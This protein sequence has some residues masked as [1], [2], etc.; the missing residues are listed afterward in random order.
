MSSRQ[1]VEITAPTPIRLS[2]HS[3]P[4]MPAR[5]LSSLSHQQAV[6]SPFGT[7]EEELSSP[8]EPEHIPITKLWPHYPDITPSPSPVPED[9]P[10]DAIAQFRE[11]HQRATGFEDDVTFWPD[12]PP[13]SPVHHL[14]TAAP[15][16]EPL[17]FFM[18]YYPIMGAFDPNQS[19]SKQLNPTAKAFE[20]QASHGSVQSTA[21]ESHHQALQ[22]GHPI[23]E[24]PPAE[25]PATEPQTEA[26][27]A[28]LLQ[29]QA[30]RQGPIRLRDLL[31]HPS[32][33]K[34]EIKLAE[35]QSLANVNRRRAMKGN[36]TA[37]S[38]WSPNGGSA[39]KSS[40]G[41][42]KPARSNGPSPISK[43]SGPFAPGYS[44]ASGSR[45]GPSNFPRYQ[46]SWRSPP[47]AK[48]SSTA[49]GTHRNSPN[50]TVSASPTTSQSGSNSPATSGTAGTSLPTSPTP[51]L[52]PTYEGKGTGGPSETV[53][54]PATPGTSRE[55]RTPAATTGEQRAYA[56]AA[57]PPRSPPAPTTGMAGMAGV[58][59]GPSMQRRGRADA[60]SWRGQPPTR[61]AEDSDRSPK[62]S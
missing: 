32:R 28:P 22:P 43:S 44:T 57:S 17:F 11:D 5:P 18:P 54:R 14:D 1:L 46:G 9:G 52:S 35:A 60:N 62:S 3:T 7:G 30:P 4:F 53:V 41:P 56:Q 31:Y 26:A 55:P 37:Q 49:P 15:V 25:P 12:S 27:I 45:N 51:S 29:Q 16:F 6:A 13:A 10:S 40:H 47:A 36:V 38:Q 21:P 58:P 23:A 8:A 61:T 2:G 50:S 42:Y 19:A 24:P 48:L 39:S 59:T 20:Y 33:K 34:K